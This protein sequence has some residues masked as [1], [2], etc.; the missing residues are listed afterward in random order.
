MFNL[1]WRIV[2]EQYSV[3]NP[4]KDLKFGTIVVKVRRQGSLITFILKKTKKDFKDQHTLCT[5]K[6]VKPLVICDTR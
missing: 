6:E 1:S 4:I 3:E 2:A 5:H